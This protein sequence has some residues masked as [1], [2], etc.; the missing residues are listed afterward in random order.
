MTTLIH[1]TAVLYS[2]RA[3]CHQFLKSYDKALA[4]AK[5]CTALDAKWWKGWSRRGSAEQCL[6]K[7][8]DAKKSYEQAIATIGSSG[9]VDAKDKKAE[10]E[11]E[12][13]KCTD[14][15]LKVLTCFVFLLPR[16]I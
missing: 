11:K 3:A 12:L 8:G 10:L 9:A 14:M 2:N 1:E 6:N 4:D 16:S 7:W 5:K 13:K 15:L